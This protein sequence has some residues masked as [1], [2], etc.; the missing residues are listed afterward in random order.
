MLWASTG[1]PDR[2]CGPIQCYGK[3]C[4]SIISGVC[5][6]NDEIPIYQLGQLR[7]MCRG[8]CG[9]GGV[10][11]LHSHIII[12]SSCC[13]LTF[14]GRRL[15]SESCL[16]AIILWW[17][18]LKGSRWSSLVDLNWSIG[19]WR[20]KLNLR[21]KMLRW[22]ALKLITHLLNCALKLIAATR[23]CRASLLVESLLL[24]FS[25]KR[26]ISYQLLTEKGLQACHFSLVPKYD[27][28]WR[29]ILKC[30][31]AMMILWSLA[32]SSVLHPPLHQK[33]T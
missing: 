33:D 4:I 13:L 15:Q 6:L 18:N 28:W 25:S 17:W 29:L 27:Y 5:K 14:L 10:S 23:E 9:V 16:L 32:G 30:P 1:R 7:L 22:G 26:E 21:K 8:M 19:P 20:N 31:R 3:G 11:R 12:P 24:L 2:L